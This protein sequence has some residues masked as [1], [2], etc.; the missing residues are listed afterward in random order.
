MPRTYDSTRRTKQ[1]AQTR[2]EVLDAAIELFGEQGWAGTT[3][4]AVAERAGVAV[5]TI[6]KTFGSKKDLLRAAMD[7]AIV[8]DAEEIPLAER[9]EYQ[10]MRE[11]TLEQ[12]AKNGMAMTATI[13]ER[14]AGVWRAIIEA[15]ASDKEIDEARRQ[16]EAGRRTE[17][18]NSFHAILERPLD[19]A[20]LDIVWAMLSPEVY[21][22]LTEDAGLSRRQYERRMHDAL[23]RIVTSQ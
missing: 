19:T 4:A 12:R 10:R 18:A 22:R 23:L 21:L 17:V 6:Y 11:G 20:T 8:G 13:H 9:P 16:L 15:A 14:S 2:A 3:L 5:E 7:V 1:A